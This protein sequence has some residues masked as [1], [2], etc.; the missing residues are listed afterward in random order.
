MP[1]FQHIERLVTALQALSDHQE[2]IHNFYHSILG[3]QIQTEGIGKFKDAFRASVSE[4]RGASLNLGN[5]AVQAFDI[6]IE[7]TVEQVNLTIDIDPEEAHR[8]LFEA[9]VKLPNI[10]QKIAAMF[11]KFLVVYLDIWPPLVPHL[12]VP[13]DT[14]VLKIIKKKLKVYTGPWTQSPSVTNQQRKIYVRGNKM[15]A[16]YQH[17]IDFQNELGA[18]AIS[19]HVPRI[20]ADE[21]WFIGYIFC[22]A[23]PLCS[24]CWVKNV[25]QDRPFE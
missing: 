18:I 23:H 5:Q 4:R 9:L 6:S 22:K 2:E 21:L 19:A 16:P 15:S 11:I 1:S 3:P 13:V 17:F 24:R 25:C 12:Y 10:N 20:L 14:V 8:I 7:T